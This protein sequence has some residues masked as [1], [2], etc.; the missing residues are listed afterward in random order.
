MRGGGNDDD[1][2]VLNKC[3]MDMYVDG[4]EVYSTKRETGATDAKA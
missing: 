3:I 1:D 4:R 2:E